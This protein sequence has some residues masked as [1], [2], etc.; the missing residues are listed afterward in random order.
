MDKE[1][2]DEMNLTELLTCL[3]QAGQ[4][5]LS[6][7]LSRKRLYDLLLKDCSPRPDERCGTVPLRGKVTDFID[8]YRDR[9]VLPISVGGQP[10][11][12]DCNT[13]GCP[14]AIAIKCHRDMT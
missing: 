4:G 10:C 13:Y 14:A 11:S 9:A 5:I 3:E 1:I 8:R 6:R 2:L 7:N 12:G